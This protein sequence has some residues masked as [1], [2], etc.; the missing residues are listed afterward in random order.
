M[1]D[2]T[3][4]RKSTPTQTRR[5]RVWSLLVIP[6]MLL[7]ACGSTGAVSGGASPGLTP[8][9]SVAVP[10]PGAS[11]NTE[12][13]TIKGQ[14]A[15]N[16][17]SCL[18]GGGCWAT[19][20]DDMT[21]QE[22]SGR[23][24]AVPSPAADSLYGI[25]CPEA[26]D[27]WAVGAT[28]AATPSNQIEH[29]DGSTWTAVSAPNDA[30]YPENGLDALACASESDCWA[31]GVSDDPSGSDSSATQTL[32]HF[33]GTAWTLARSPM[34]GAGANLR[35]LQCPSVSQCLFFQALGVGALSQ[36]VAVLAEGT[37]RDTTVPNVL[38][39]ASSCPAVNDCYAIGRGE[40]TV[41][42][43]AIWHWDGSKWTQRDPIPT[44]EG[45]IDMDALYCP[46]D[47]TCW[48]GGG[49][50]PSGSNVKALVLVDHTGSWT[51]PAQPSTYGQYTALSCPSASS[52]WA[53]AASARTASASDSRAL[54]V[55]LT[56]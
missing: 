56:I 50:P 12:A 40:I 24:T 22:R 43:Q 52:C 49:E 6:A 15:I 9:T 38:F 8:T 5:S 21:E 32:L 39:V 35:M 34:S 7:T 55:R 37:W 41:R 31:A 44:E 54:V 27:C 42:S 3:L 20:G 53:G 2:G 45:G 33:D 4:M 51:A 14:D 18:A 13:F 47:G 1:L 28:R 19:A 10:P 23:W 29:Y 30:I 16:A 17:L 36:N 46:N 26:T 48:V 11:K 25:D